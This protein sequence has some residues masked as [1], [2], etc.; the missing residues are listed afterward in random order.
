MSENKISGRVVKILAAIA[1]IVSFTIFYKED[2]HA[3][4]FKHVHTDSCYKA[5][6]KECTNHKIEVMIQTHEYHCTTCQVMRDFQ[7]IIYWDVCLSGL[8]SRHD[9]AYK[10]TCTV[11]GARRRYEE[12]GK[13]GGHKYTGKSLECGMDEN[14]SIANISLSPSST[15]PTNGSVTLSIGVS[16]AASEFSLAAAPYNFGAGNTSE[17]SFEVNENGTYNA[18]VTDSL[19]RTVT[20]SCTVSS[21]DKINPVIDAISKSTEAWTESGLTITV[22]AHDEGLGLSGEAFSFNGGDFG[23]GNIY[24]VTA[25]GTVSVRVKDAAGNVSESSINIANI[26]R[27]P[28]VVEAE[29]KEAERK[30]AEKAAAEKAEA[31]RIAAEKAAAEKAAAEKAASE[32]AAAEKAA[33]EKASKAQTLKDTAKNSSKSLKAEKSDKTVLNETD[34]K[35]I[36]GKIRD[37]ATSGGAII[38][39]NPGLA[40][41][42]KLIVVRDLTDSEDD[43]SETAY[44]SEEVIESVSDLAYDSSD[45]Q[46]YE[47]NASDV[48]VQGHSILQASV[49]GYTV[50]AGILLLLAGAFFISRFS[51]VYVMQCG[52]RHLISR[53]RIIKGQ[54]GLTA[55]VPGNKL[56]SHGKYLLYI[57]PWKKG[58]NKKIPVSVMLEG[59]ESVIPTD[60]GIAF[61][62]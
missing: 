17:S 48:K 47:D 56:T 3:A 60:E 61:K 57:S 23:A 8:T 21:I 33:A 50:S 54:N 38:S 1:V 41:D 49:G 4:S 35:D 13:I 55:V 45:L 34:D 9:V 58:F 59:E 24:K 7:E 16:D 29:R 6:T 30:A 44:E 31:E 19:G 20:V 42:G 46:E 10:Q 15:A 39:G 51:Y 14:T 18:T 32:K 12:P 52:K 36:F 26:G 22:D 11:C 5:V 40:G 37:T 53:C 62:Y 2:S 27:D 43:N 25:N 28:K